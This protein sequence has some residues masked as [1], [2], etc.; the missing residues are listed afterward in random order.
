MSRTINDLFEVGSPIN[1]GSQTKR[2]MNSCRKR[3]LSF[4]SRETETGFIDIL[5][6][7]FI[8]FESRI[9]NIYISDNIDNCD[10]MN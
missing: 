8:L 4:T 7:L 5:I 9:L 3:I 10:I 1:V 2:R 6:V